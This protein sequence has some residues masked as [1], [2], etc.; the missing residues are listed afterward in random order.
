MVAASVLHYRTVEAKT[1]PLFHATVV[2]RGYILANDIQPFSTLIDE[3]A[4]QDEPPAPEVLPREYLKIRAEEEGANYNVLNRIA[5]CESKWRMV[6]NSES[7]AY[8]YFQ[9]LEGTE[10]FT[11]EYKQ[12]RR[13]H[14]PYANIDMAIFLYKADGT[15]PWKESEPCWSQ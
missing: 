3:L 7:T 1:R 6:G 2:T 5:M 11:P 13:R 4:F 8:G 14:D 10:K 15:E 12:G 9:I